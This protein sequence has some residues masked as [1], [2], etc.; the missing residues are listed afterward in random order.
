VG[1]YVRARAL[2]PVRCAC[3]GHGNTKCGRLCAQKAVEI[4]GR[5]FAEVMGKHFVSN[6]ISEDFRT[7]VQHVSTLCTT[8]PFVACT[9]APIVERSSVPRYFPSPSGIVASVSTYMH[10]RSRAHTH[11]RTHTRTY[12]HTRRCAHHTH[13]RQC[14]RIYRHRHTHT[15]T[16]THTQVLDS[17]L[18]HGQATANFELTLFTKNGSRVEV[19]RAH[20]HART[21]ACARKLRA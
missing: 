21:C 12:A 5:T 16:H 10:A 3:D 1:A 18:K 11:A 8:L 19:P 9:V 20:A 17:A 14:A 4:T 2:R 13:A 7:S 6:F 15:H